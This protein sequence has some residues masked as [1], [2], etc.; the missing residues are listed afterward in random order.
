MI[1]TAIIIAIAH[2]LALAGTAITHGTIHGITLLMHGDIMIHGIIAVGVGA[3][4]GII[5]AGAMAMA[6]TVITHGTEVGMVAAG[7][8]DITITTGIIVI[9]T[10]IQDVPV[11]DIM[12]PVVADMQVQV[13]VRV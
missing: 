13:A 7:M 9:N 11:Q 4:L 12:D 3:G 2:D 5:V 1:I 6:G 10:T 8:A